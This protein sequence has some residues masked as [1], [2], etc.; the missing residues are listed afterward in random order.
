MLYQSDTEFS[1]PI[2]TTVAG[3]DA[4]RYDYTITSYIYPPVTDENGEYVFDENGQY[5]LSEDR[6]I[7]GIFKNRIYF[8]FSDEDVFYII[9]EATEENAEAAQADFDKF[10]ESVTISKK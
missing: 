3:F 7:N 10:I 1:E 8:F 9:C 5:V 2:K 6:E 4:I